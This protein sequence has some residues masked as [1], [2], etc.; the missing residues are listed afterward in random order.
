MHPETW[1]NHEML[2]CMWTAFFFRPR[3]CHGNVF[4]CVCLSVCLSVCLYYF[5]F[6]RVLTSNAHFGVQVHPRRMCRPSWYVKV[7]GPRSQE[8]TAF[9]RSCSRCFA[10]K[11]ILCRSPYWSTRVQKW[12]SILVAV[13]HMNVLNTL[14]SQS[15]CYIY[16]RRLGCI[17]LMDPH[18]GLKVAR[19]ARD[20]RPHTLQFAGSIR[21][22]VKTLLVHK[23][24]RAFTR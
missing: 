5:N 20:R 1:S 15:A 24:I 21:G 10:S 7:I 13:L 19:G 11:V 12:R 9:C 17:L 18:P 23:M 16:R 3:V 2:K 4:I 8:Q 14:R 22:L 6:L